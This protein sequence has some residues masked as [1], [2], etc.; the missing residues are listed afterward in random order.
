MP[1]QIDSHIFKVFEQIVQNHP[2]KIAITYKEKDNFLTLTYEQLLRRAAALGEYLRSL[3]LQSG[4]KAAIILE[5]SQYPIAFFGCLAINATAVP[6]DNQF[7]PD[8]LKSVI[9]HAEAKILITTSKI[10]GALRNA[11][12]NF[13]IIELDEEGLQERLARG[14]SLENAGDH[15]E[16]IPAVLFYTSGTTDHPKVVVLSHRNLLSNVY[17]IKELNIVEMNDM[18]VSVLPLHHA[19]SFTVTMLI[20]LLLGASIVYPAGLASH[21]I[22]TAMPASQATILVGVP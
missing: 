1:P 8:Q 22:L 17:S 20:P 14:D 5:N 18:V 11:L 9:H 16:K 21:D 6:L 4:D 7:P 13:K 19:Y 2:A 15:K 10:S 3:G 12:G